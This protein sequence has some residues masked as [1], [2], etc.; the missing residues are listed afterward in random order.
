MAYYTNCSLH[1]RM[2]RMKM[3]IETVEKTLTI[4]VGAAYMA[5]PIVTPKAASER[6]MFK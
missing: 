5:P 1:T 2:R 6:Q 4:N 3:N